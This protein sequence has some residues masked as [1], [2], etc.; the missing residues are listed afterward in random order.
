MIKSEQKQTLKEIEQYFCERMIELMDLGLIE[1]SDSLY[2][3]FIVNDKEP[4]S[5]DWVFMLNS[6][7]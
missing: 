1:E 6:E 3:E 2:A 5:K 4:T 7:K